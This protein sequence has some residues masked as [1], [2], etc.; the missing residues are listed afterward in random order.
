MWNNIR[1]D[2][3]RWYGK[4][5]LLLFVK[6]FLSQKGF[7]FVLLMRLAKHGRK[8]PVLNLFFIL[9][10][11]VSKVIYTSDVNYRATIGPGLRMHHVFGTT[12]GEHVRIGR[13]ATI[14]H[15]VTIAGKNGEWPVIGDNVY[16][17]TGCCILGGINIGN[18]VVVGA[19]AVVTK[20]VPDNAIVAGIPAKVVSEK[21]SADFVF[22]PWSE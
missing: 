16:L 17:G 3:F 4:Y 12:W 8:I 2:V 20:D 22:N 15:N 5:S 1:A 11:K 6:A 21:G 9:F 14:V 10:Y 19:N 7:R 13:N 18:N